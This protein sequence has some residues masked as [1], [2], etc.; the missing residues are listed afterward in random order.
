MVSL[1][2]PS[3]FGGTVIHA[4]SAPYEL[5]LGNQLGPCLTKEH[6]LRCRHNIIKRVNLFCAKFKFALLAQDMYHLGTTVYVSV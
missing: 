2:D 3:P 1:M 6:M 5:Y 4:S